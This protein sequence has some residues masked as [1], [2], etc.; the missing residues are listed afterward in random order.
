MRCWPGKLRTRLPFLPLLEALIASGSDTLRAGADGT[1]SFHSTATRSGLLVYS[2]SDAD[3]DS[4]VAST[5]RHRRIELGHDVSAASPPRNAVKHRRTHG[6][7]P[8]R[9]GTLP[10]NNAGVGSGREMEEE[11]LDGEELFQNDGSAISPFDEK[12]WG[13]SYG[14]TQRNLEAFLSSIESLGRLKADFRRPK[15]PLEIRIYA[16]LGAEMNQKSLYTRKR[17][18]LPA[19]LCTSFNVRVKLTVFVAST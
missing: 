15:D 10:R 6:V 7:T 3:D 14:V 8:K 11:V 9:W 2:R 4:F 5:D 13:T 18:L 19:A 12:S 17:R 16:S 1:R